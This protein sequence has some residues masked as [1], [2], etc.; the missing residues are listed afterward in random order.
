MNELDRNENCSNKN[1]E[2]INTLMR[3]EL[4]IGMLEN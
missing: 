2:D 3:M 1:F 4:N